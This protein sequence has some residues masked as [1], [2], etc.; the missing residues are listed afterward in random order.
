[1][2]SGIAEAA[3]PV[4]EA[5]G[6]GTLEKLLKRDRLIIITGIVV[7]SLASWGYHDAWRMRDRFVLQDR[8]GDMP[9]HRNCC[10]VCDV[11]GDDGRHDDADGRLM[12]LDAAVN[13]GGGK[14][15]P[16]A[17]GIFLLGY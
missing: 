17:D 12:V 2:S 6:E 4:A 13:R 7:L 1:M 11:G 14:Q 5:S 15:K 9:G 10:S 3:D 16:Y 8:D